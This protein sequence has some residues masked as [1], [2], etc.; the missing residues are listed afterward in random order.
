MATLGRSAPVAFAPLAPRFCGLIADDL[1]GRELPGCVGLMGVAWALHAIEH[2]MLAIVLCCSCV[3]ATYIC[4]HVFH[5]HQLLPKLRRQVQTPGKQLA[6]SGSW[7]DT[8][9]NVALKCQLLKVGR[10]ETSLHC[11]QKYALAIAWTMSPIPPQSLSLCQNL[12]QA[13]APKDTHGWEGP[14]PAYL[15]ALERVLHLVAGLT[16]NDP[17]DPA[18]D[19]FG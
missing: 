1:L 7:G 14:D 2:G 13:F 11:V 15:R 4:G 16:S 10:N 8:S 6:A 18:F 19:A 3:L 5:A 9:P 17:G 12:T